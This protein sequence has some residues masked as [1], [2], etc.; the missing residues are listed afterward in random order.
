MDSLIAPD[1]NAS[2]YVDWMRRAIA[3]EMT[4]LELIGAAEALAGQGEPALQQQLYKVW[5]EHNPDAPLLHAVNFN[6]GVTLSGA[7]DLPRARDAFA[8]AIRINP[9]FLPPYIN[10]G[11]LLERNGHVD[12]AAQQWLNL[13]NRL[14]KVTGDAILHKSL[15]L[16]QLGRVLE[17][18]QDPSNAENMLERSLDLNPHQRDAIQHCIA[19]RMGQCKWPVVKPRGTLTRKTLMNAISPLSLAAYSD[20]PLLQLGN[21]YQYCKLEVTN[22]HAPVAVT[23]WAPAGTPRPKRL[24]I[25]FLSSDLREH[26]VGFLTSE[27]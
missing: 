27:I 13:V 7:G 23:R 19:L 2:R 25:G 12:Q 10:L 3:H 8:E 24:R 14:D 18:A 17:G 22:P 20:D 26:A 5:I 16:K 4:A 15:A 21:A 6:Y 11:T 1:L 9:D